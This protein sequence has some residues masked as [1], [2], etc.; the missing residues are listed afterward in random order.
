MQDHFSKYLDQTA[1]PE[2]KLLLQNAIETLSQAGREDHVFFIDQMM[3]E[4]DVGDAGDFLLRVHVML[5]QANHVMLKQFGVTLDDDCELD[6]STDILKGILSMDNWSDPASI[7]KQCESTETSEV[8]LATLLELVGAYH[9]S[10]Y[11]PHLER[12][13]G[14]L[15][16]RIDTLNQT[17]DDSALPSE[18][19]RERAQRRVEAFFAR[20]S[21][22]ILSQAIGEMLLIGGGYHGLMEPYSEAIGDLPMDTAVN[23]LVGFALASDLPNEKLTDAIAEECQGWWDGDATK[24]ASLSGMVRKRLKDA[25]VL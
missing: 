7:S 6:M 1:T 23:E 18:E 9:E 17:F 5:N 13:S 25:N 3:E 2:R 19:E 16:D 14:D 24:A 21:A 11:L 12:V 20:Y 4:E 8:V 15:I 10:D 22:P